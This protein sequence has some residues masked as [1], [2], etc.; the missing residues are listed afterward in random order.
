M[1]PLLHS[2]ISAKKFGGKPDDYQHLH[3]WMDHTK[4]HIPDARHRM[5]LHNSWGIYLG[6]Q[7]F[8]VSFK[9]SDGKDVIV[10]DVLEQHVIDDLGHI[11]TLDK[12]FAEFSLE[13]WMG[14]KIRGTGP[15]L[16]IRDIGKYNIEIVD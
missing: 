10:R 12:C 16:K 5:L 9:N 1:K 4:A 11:P 3:D 6:E 8:G 15:R 14:S 13:P 2:K 7:I